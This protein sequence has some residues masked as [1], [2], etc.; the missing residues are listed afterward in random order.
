MLIG[1]NTSLGQYDLTV[2]VI[3]L[4]D[5]SVGK[6]SLLRNL[7]RFSSDINFQGNTSTSSSS[8]CS[9]KRESLSGGQTRMNAIV[10]S[11]VHS[12]GFVDVEFTHQDKTVLTRIADT[13]G[14][15][16][17]MICTGINDFSKVYRI[18]TDIM[19]FL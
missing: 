12:G 11:T 2:K 13:G 19:T 5:Y 14:E 4:G 16:S 9:S 8:S 3:L 15:L 7:T 6:S 17:F 10:R 18:C 1:S